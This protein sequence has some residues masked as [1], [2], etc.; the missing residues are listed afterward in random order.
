MSFNPP[1]EGLKPGESVV[2]ARKRGTSFW[3]IWFSG[4]LGIGGF[5]AIVFALIY[6][7]PI[8]A[9][10][11]LILV[12]IGFLFIARD[13]IRGIGTKYYLTDERIIEARKGKIVQEISL[14][15][16]QG[17]PL[18][19][20]FEKNVIGMANN[21]PI[22]VIKVYDPTSGDILVEFKDLDESSIESLERIGQTVECLYCSFKNPVNSLTCRNCG[23]SL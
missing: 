21:Q 5:M 10:P 14:E 17:K 1:K 3:V 16:F 6:V 9:V 19:Q 11:L 2:W 22:Y 20:F 15:R 23:A 18:S 12:I 7:G 8:L 13:F 4:V